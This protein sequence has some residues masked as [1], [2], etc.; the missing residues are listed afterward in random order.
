MKDQSKPESYAPMAVSTGSMTFNRTG[1]WRYLRPIYQEKL[2][3]CRSSCPAGT[4]V[5]RVLRLI[6]EG[7]FEEA[8]RSI[9]V[10]NPLSA[11]C[12]H[13]CYHPCESLC[14]RAKLDGGVSV[15]ALERFVSESFYDLPIERP[16]LI[17]KESVAIIGSG[18]AGLSCA[19]YLALKGFK[20]HIYEAADKPGGMLRIGI[21]KYRMPREIIDREIKHITDLGV[22][23]SCSCRI[24][25]DITLAQLQEKHDAV[26]IATG[27]HRSRTIGL[28]TS[29]DGPIWSGLRFLD[30]VNQNTDPNIGEKAAIIGGGNTAIDTARVALRLG[31]EPTIIYRRTREEMP[32]HE[33]E[34]RDAEKEGIQIIYLATPLS[35]DEDGSKLQITFNRMRL[36]EPGEDGRRRPEMIQGDTFV[37]KVDTLIEAIGEQPDLSFVGTLSEKDGIFIGGDASTGPSTVVDA[38][39]AGK[40]IAR[41]IQKFLGFENFVFDA[42]PVQLGHFER[43]TLNYEYFPTIR[44][45]TIPKMP[46]NER[47]SNFEEIVRTLGTDDAIHEAHRCMSCGVCNSCDTCYIH[48]PEAAISKNGTSYDINLDYCKGCGICVQECPRGVI[49]LIQEEL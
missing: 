13:V 8:Y 1:S 22:E 27:A 48:C 23:L 11:I 25:N 31:A 6:G 21:P 18:P 36:Q 7:K 5:P 49:T 17:H 19:H 40:E 28:G 45:T 34:L 47:K 43:E 16:D 24:G 14:S 15:Q 32:A 37:L 41:R 46:S 35:V 4:D 38:I 33:T 39:A 26:F 12:G 9:R 2:A 42:P 44:P 20:V 3:P 10:E 30:R 29:A